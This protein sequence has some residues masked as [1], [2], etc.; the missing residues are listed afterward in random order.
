MSQSKYF[1]ILELDEIQSRCKLSILYF[2][3]AKMDV[4]ID[5]YTFKSVLGKGTFG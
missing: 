1:H 4:Q 2:V 3:K 5:D